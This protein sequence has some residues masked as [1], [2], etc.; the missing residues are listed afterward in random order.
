MLFLSFQNKYNISNTN[1]FNIEVTQLTVS[2]YFDQRVVATVTN[3][4]HQTIPLRAT[5]TYEV[6]MNLTFSGDEG[7]IA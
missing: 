6:Q 3:D 4:T 5:G 2:G 1:F 7:Y